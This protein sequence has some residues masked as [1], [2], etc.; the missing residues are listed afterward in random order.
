MHLEGANTSLFNLNLDQNIMNLTNSPEL[1]DTEN[2]ENQNTLTF[3][4]S[5]SSVDLPDQ[6]KGLIEKEMHNKNE[7]AALLQ[8]KE[9]YSERESKKLKLNLE[10]EEKNE[11][12]NQNKQKS[13]M[14]L[15]HFG[16]IIPLIFNKEGEAILVI[17]PHC[18]NK[19][20]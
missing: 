3:H 1:L 13:S 14:K 17:G 11:N 12:E 15:K 9:N 4:C 7:S 6:E 2:S 8:K 20:L 10:I 18:K 5:K 19:L 16:N